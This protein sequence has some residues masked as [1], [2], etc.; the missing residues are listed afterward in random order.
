MIMIDYKTQAREFKNAYETSLKALR[1]VEK[2]SPS[3]FYRN[4]A[5][6]ARWRLEK[7]KQRLKRLNYE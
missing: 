5:K 4:E 6:K 7:V 1:E 2:H 3:P